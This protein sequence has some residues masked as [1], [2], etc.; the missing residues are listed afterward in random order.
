MWAKYTILAVAVASLAAVTADA[1]LYRFG[2]ETQKSP[3][4][5]GILDEIVNSPARVAGESTLGKTD[6]FFDGDIKA[7]NE[8][9]AIYFQAERPHAYISI[10]TG[11]HRA[12]LQIQHVGDRGS[13]LTV[14]V[15]DEKELAALDLPPKLAV[16]AMPPISESLNPETKAR[17]KE[18][19]KAVKTR[20]E[21]HAK[22]HSKAAED[23][24]KNASSAETPLTETST[25]I[26]EDS[27]ADPKK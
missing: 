9:I 18:L 13:Y 19:W 24:K 6:F 22:E 14:Y 5:T 16:E 26:K 8:L 12:K 25:K 15:R 2:R 27:A 3:L 10:G 23:T 20:A 11:E 4:W 7:A 17:E 1:A 21:Q